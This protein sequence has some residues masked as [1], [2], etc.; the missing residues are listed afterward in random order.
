MHPAA[1]KS[2]V[3]RAESSADLEAT[4]L[5]VEKFTDDSRRGEYLRAVCKRYGDDHEPTLK[6]AENVAAGIGALVALHKA[7]P[8]TPAASHDEALLRRWAKSHPSLSVQF[9]K[10]TDEIGAARAPHTEQFRQQRL[11]SER[12]AIAKR[13]VKDVIVANKQIILL[14]GGSFSSDML[15]AFNEFHPATPQWGDWLLKE[16]SQPLKHGEVD[17]AV[18]SPNC[19][20]VVIILNPASHA[21]VEQ[22]RDAVKRHK[23]PSVAINNSSKTA[24][25]EGIT[26]LL[27]AMANSPQARS[28]LGEKPKIQTRA[29]N[30]TPHNEP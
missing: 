2:I 19:A 11:G 28:T 21:I 12:T 20:G 30:V 29:T 18:G 6:A 4:T 22:A 25:R 14:V 8:A 16:R 10:Y 13:F 23:K 17:E 5:L 26:A 7:A 15:D 24:L 1:A 9:L 3:A 27:I